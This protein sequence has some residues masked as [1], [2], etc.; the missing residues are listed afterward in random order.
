M[1]SHE[2]AEIFPRAVVL[3]VSSHAGENWVGSESCH[4]EK[5]CVS[6]GLGRG[7]L[8]GKC[9]VSRERRNISSC[10][11]TCMEMTSSSIVLLVE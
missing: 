3:S 1:W 11:Q 7:N 6:P 4:R 10:K 9:Q 8:G 2:G 5:W